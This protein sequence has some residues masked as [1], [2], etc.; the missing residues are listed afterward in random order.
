MTVGFFSPAAARAHRGGRLFRVAARRTAAPRARGN[1]AR[2][3][4]M[5]RST[6]W[7]TTACTRRSTGGP[8][9]AAGSGGAARCRAQP[10][11][12]GATRAKRRMWTSSSTTTANG[13]AAL[14]GELWRARAGSAA[15]ERYFRYPMLKRIGGAR[16]GR[17]GPQSGGRRGGEG[18][19]A[20]A[21]AWWRFRT[22]SRP[23][24][25]PDEAGRAALPR[26]ARRANR[27]PSC[28]AFSD[29]C[30]S[31]S[32]WPR[33]WR[34]SPRVHA[35]VPRAGL[36]IAGQFVSTDL[37]RAVA[38]LLDAPGVCPPAVSGGERVLAGGARRGCLHQSA[39]SG[40]GREFRDRGSHDGNR[41]AGAAHGG[42]GM[43]RVSRRM[44]ACASPPGRRERDSLWHH[45]VL[46]TSMA[47]V[48]R[49]IG[50]RGAAHIAAH[51]RVERNR[52]AILG[53]SVRKLYLIPAWLYRAGICR[54]PP[55]PRQSPS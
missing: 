3:A 39:L 30:A 27:R 24:P 29:I 12:P 14:G 23:P 54:A 44:P 38:P 37:E 22:C 41:Q 18:T 19:R 5:S 11:P 42:A 48:A 26:F 40:G 36:L 34:R 51:H 7:G 6:T 33:C 16:A 28:S 35:R 43:R 8:S 55:W 53:P 49:A 15:D 4:A 1:R 46:L 20:A 25:L 17:G 50:Q 13:I 21:R 9:R 47:E 2:S 52:E 32:G 45:M 31:P 10:L